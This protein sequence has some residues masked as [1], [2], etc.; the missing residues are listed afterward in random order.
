MRRYLI[1]LTMLTLS[2]ALAG[3]ALAEYGT[4]EDVYGLSG[5]P[6][7]TNAAFMGISAGS[8]TDLYTVGMMQTG[9]LDIE[10][11]WASKDAG[12]SWTAVYGVHMGGADPCDMMK[13]FNMVF[14]LEAIGPNTAVMVGFGVMDE[15]LEVLEIPWCMFVCMFTMSP[16]V[17]YTDDGGNTL[18][19]ANTPFA[20]MKIPMAIDYSEEMVGYAAGGPDLLMRS[21]DGGAN[22]ENLENFPEEELYINDLDFV[23]ADVGWIVTGDSDP[24]KVVGKDEPNEALAFR[25]QM[26]HRY[27]FMHDA[28]YR[29][30]FQEEH[31]NLSNK[32]LNGHIYKTTDGGET[33]E[34][35][36]RSPFEGFSFIQMLD[37]QTGWVMGFPTT[38]YWPPFSLYKTEDGGANWV[39]YTERVPYDELGN[40]PL[41]VS[42]MTFSPSGQT[43][44]LGG[45]SQQ[46]INYT[47]LLFYSTD[48]GETW[49]WDESLL[50]WGHP[51]L[52]FDWWGEKRAWQAGFDLSIYRYTQVNVAPIADA[53]EDQEVDQNAA[54]TLDGSDS[55]DPDED[56]ITYAWV[57][58]DGPTIELTGADEVMPTFIATETGDLTFQL[59]V[60]DGEEQGTDDVLI[61]VTAVADDDVADDDVAD[62]D[63]ADDDAADDDVAD[64]DAAGDDDDDDDGCGC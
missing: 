47:S 19:K 15:C 33:W 14:A 37:D 18:E 49:E 1:V 61:T 59:T 13:M 48:G 11:A 2:L 51:I 43:A 5:P 45:A 62:D 36:L 10:Y 8:E 41:G 9:A 46:F 64:D 23:T 12:E 24:E 31:P 26:I 56:P 53:G 6:G 30:K 55:Y 34:M 42:A 3:S 25:E 29:L 60:D 22:W 28:V 50:P 58:T 7:Y 44:F 35:Q 57:Q 17:L 20:L 38:G 4:W 21:Y 63:V 54:V 40:L 27:R 39:D 16:L 32:G 52:S